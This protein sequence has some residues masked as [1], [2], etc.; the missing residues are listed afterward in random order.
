MTVLLA[1]QV[2]GYVKAIYMH[3]FPYCIEYGLAVGELVYF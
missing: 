1:H 2:K 3:V